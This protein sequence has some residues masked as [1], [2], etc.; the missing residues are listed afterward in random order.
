MESV[1]KTVRQRIRVQ[2]PIS[3]EL[4]AEGFGTCLVV[5]IGCASIAQFVIG[6]G[7]RNAW[8]GLSLAWGFAVAF[9]IY[10]SWNITGGHVNPAISI[11]MYV[12]GNLTLVRALLYSLAQTIGAFFGAGIVYYTYYDAISKFDHGTRAVRGV[13]ATAGIFASYPDAYVSVFGGLL[14]QI[15][16]TAIL[17]L[18]ICMVT[19]RRNHI[20]GHL[21][22]LLI[23]LG[24]AA[25]AM[26]F[27]MNCGAPLNP[28]RDL[29]PRL[30]TLIAGYGWEVFSYNDYT[31]FWVP[32]LGPIIGALIG[33]WV[34]KL[35]IG[36]H[37]P[38]E[39][40]DIELAALK[41]NRRQVAE[42]VVLIKST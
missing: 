39:E 4:L 33:A 7:E 19:D 37:W 27:G 36:L 23:G 31:W 9:G 2:S 41:N 30:F 11:M 29:G 6:N 38:H 40:V 22:P 28:A 10:V 21:G 24:V 35:F 26:S 16:G 25:I 8:I 32:I 12:L 13:G 18:I 20:P 34:Y 3:R 42:D 15:V 1:R 17:G 5:T 14:D